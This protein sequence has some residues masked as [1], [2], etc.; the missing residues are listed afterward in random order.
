MPHGEQIKTR[1]DDRY[2]IFDVPPIL[3]GADAIAFAPLVDGI[4]MVVEERRT[5][6]QDIKKALDLI[7]MEKFLGF[8][9]NRRKSPPRKYYY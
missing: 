7:P 3:G 9:L 4:L 8:V 6:I 1:Y 5:P 2:V